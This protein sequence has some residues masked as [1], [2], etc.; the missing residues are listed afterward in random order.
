MQER[1][2]YNYTS[3]VLEQAVK[4]VKAGKMNTYQAARQYNIPRSTIA[5]KIYKKFRGALT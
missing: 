1:K 3:E 5:N 4:E 2:R